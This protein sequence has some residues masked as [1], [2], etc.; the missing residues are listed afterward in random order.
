VRCAVVDDMIGCTLY[1]CRRWTGDAKRGYYANSTA[2]CNTPWHTRP[3]T[4]PPRT[5]SDNRNVPV[6]LCCHRTALF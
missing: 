4:C 2:T 1:R 6:C 5:V 3:T